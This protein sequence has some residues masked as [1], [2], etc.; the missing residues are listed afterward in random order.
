M[1]M[2][3]Q[4]MPLQ[5]KPTPPTW[6]FKGPLSDLTFTFAGPVTCLEIER[7]TQNSKKMQDMNQCLI[8]ALLYF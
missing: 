6:H 4:G 1:E 2:M 5:Q 8:P 7:V 3:V